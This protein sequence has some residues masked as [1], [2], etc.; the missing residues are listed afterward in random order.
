MGEIH[1]QGVF[2]AAPWPDAIRG[3]K[4]R[5][6]RWLS[7]ARRLPFV[8]LYRAATAGKRGAPGIVGGERVAGDFVLKCW[9]AAGNG[10][11]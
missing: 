11:H 4:G 3:R 10:L 8:T 2:R 1:A 9:A 5:G 6:G 7:G